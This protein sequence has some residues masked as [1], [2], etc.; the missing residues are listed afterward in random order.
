MIGRDSLQFA[1]KADQPV[2]YLVL[3]IDPQGRIVTLWP[4]SS[5]ENQPVPAGTIE[6]F[7][8]TAATDPE[9]LDQVVVLAFQ[10]PPA[11]IDAWYA[12]A[13]PF[14][15]AEASGLVQWLAGAGLAYAAATIDVRTIRT[16]Q[17]K[18]AAP[19]VP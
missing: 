9:G 18:E 6:T 1:V 11:G 4:T 15:S 7:G 19:C 3:D 5:E 13:A 2:W 14:G 10:T 8:Q 16:C 12:L 17:T